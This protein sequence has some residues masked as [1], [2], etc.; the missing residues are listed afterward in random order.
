MCG[1]FSVITKNCEQDGIYVGNP[2]RMV[3]KHNTRF[4]D[5]VVCSLKGGDYNVYKD[6]KNVK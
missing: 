5:I 2:A 3:R 1:A 6:V 4:K